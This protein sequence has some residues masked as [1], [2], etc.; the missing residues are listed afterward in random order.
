[1][2]VIMPSWRT[3]DGPLVAKRLLYS[4]NEGLHVRV[5]YFND[6]MW[7]PLSLLLA[8]S[9][10]RR[11]ASGTRPRARTA[12]TRSGTSTRPCCST[13]EITPGPECVPRPLRPGVHPADVH[14]PHAEQ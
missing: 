12:C 6:F 5:S 3:P 9:P 11:R 14:A 2:R 8:S 13:P 1:M 4:G 7:S 10:C